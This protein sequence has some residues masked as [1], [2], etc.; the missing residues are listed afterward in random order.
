MPRGRR[1][2]LVD[3]HSLGAL[4]AMLGRRADRLIHDSMHSISGR[5]ELEM[6]IDAHAPHTSKF[7]V[8]YLRVPEALASGALKVDDAKAH[9]D[10]THVL[11]IRLAG[12]HA[13]WRGAMLCLRAVMPETMVD[14]IVGKRLGDVV[15]GVGREGAVITAAW[16]DP[17]TSGPRGEDPGTRLLLEA[18]FLDVGDLVGLT[19]RIA[20]PFRRTLLDATRRR[21]LAARGW[22]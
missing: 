21:R 17:G 8:E 16:N 3:D 22:A 12:A 20:G 1:R 5:H 15:S 19:S 4:R 7:Y 9:P 10:A 6:A 18:D 11:Q 14:Q 13:E 2:V